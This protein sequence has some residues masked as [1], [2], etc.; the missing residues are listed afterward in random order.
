MSYK[1]SQSLPFENKW[2]VKNKDIEFTDEI[3]IKMDKRK[4][5]SLIDDLAVKHS[6]FCY[7]SD[8]RMIIHR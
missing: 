3:R 8:L 1:Y 7:N 4:K 6:I 2:Y 5:S